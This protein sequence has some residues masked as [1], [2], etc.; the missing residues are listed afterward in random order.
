MDGVFTVLDPLF[1]LIARE[2]LF[3]CL[4]SSEVQLLTAVAAGLAGAS[5]QLG[6]SPKQL[7]R[8]DVWLSPPFAC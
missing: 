6:E 3:E 1:I 5:R 8:R 4:G 2:R 7:A